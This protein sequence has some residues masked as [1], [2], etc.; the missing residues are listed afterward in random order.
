M[1]EGSD[2]LGRYAGPNVLEPYRS[3]W[4]NRREAPIAECQVMGA[5]GRPETGFGVFRYEDV[6]AV[7]RNSAAFSSESIRRAL[8]PLM[9]QFP[10]VGLDD[11]DHRELRPRVAHAFR[12]AV[13]S[14]WER[15]TNSIIHGLIDRFIGAGHADLV[16]DFTFRF[17]ARVIAAILGLPPEDQPRFHRWAIRI[18]N[19]RNY[20]PSGLGAGRGP[21]DGIRASQQ[22]RSYL[23][24]V[25]N[26]RRREP[27]DDL[28]SDLARTS[29]DGV[30]LGDEQIFSFVSLLLP[31][32]AQTTHAATG[33]L[34]FALLSQREQMNALR[35]DRRLMAQSIE[36]AIR[37]EPPL[38]TVARIANR[39]V[40][41]RG[42]TIPAGAQVLASIGSANHDESRW[43]EPERFNIFRDRQPSIV[44]GSGIHVCLGAHLAKMEMALAVDAILDRCQ[45]LAFDPDSAEPTMAGELFRLPTALPVRFTPA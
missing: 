11:P 41:L 36:E 21:G 38:M 23:R 7:L 4:T 15:L 9:G 17:P 19:G 27:R 45:S 2:A 39:D 34:L 1:N 12:P 16:R 25:V 18:I 8:A 22:L 6:S 43:D 35:D 28:L 32:G 3:F 40:D 20:D 13:L 10:L 44:F 30:Q 26:A 24:H 14:S 31:A 5:D 42:I 29:I 33:S 37:W